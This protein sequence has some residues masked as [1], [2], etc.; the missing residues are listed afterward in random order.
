MDEM[1]HHTRAVVRGSVRA[2]VVFDMP[3]MSYQ[4]SANEAVRNA[5]R[6]LKEGGAQSIKFEGGAR[7]APLVSRLVDSGIPVMGH[8]GLGPQS[9]NA[10][11][12]YKAQGTD[13]GAA[14]RLL[15]DAHALADAG[16]WGMV[17]ERIPSELAAVV[18]REVRVPTVGIAAGPDCDGQVQVMH[19]LLGLDERF[20]PRHS[21]AYAT[22]AGTIRDAFAAYAADVRAGTFPV[23]QHGVKASDILRAHLRGRS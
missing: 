17:L 1:L 9:V 3:F 18:T 21:G 13:P 2:H 23:E 11:G 20:R 10:I 19:D 5:G 12:G 4:A 15:E 16:V 8:I 22:L 7:Y 6:A 14:D